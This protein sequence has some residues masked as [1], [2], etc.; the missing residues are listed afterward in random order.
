MQDEYHKPSQDRHTPDPVAMTKTEQTKSYG[1]LSR[2]ALAY[3]LL[4]VFLPSSLAQLGVAAPGIVLSAVVVLGLNMALIA[5]FKRTEQRSLEKI[6]CHRIGLLTAVFTL[7]VTSML[8]IYSLY[9]LSAS[10][11]TITALKEN[12]VIPM[13]VISGAIGFAINYVVVTYGLWLLQ[14][15]QSR[16]SKS[17]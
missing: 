13:L 3:T 16:L 6:E 5:L 14:S 4:Y 17:A 9:D 2:F 7:I 8:M 11:L 12:G 10:E 15:L 1:Y